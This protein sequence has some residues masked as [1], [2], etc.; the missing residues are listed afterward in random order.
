MK[1]EP[2]ILAI[3]TADKS[4][5]VALLKGRKTL[6]YRK[7]PKEYRR[8][9]KL[10]PSV[11]RVLATAGI[12]K[13]ELDLVAVN[14]GP[15]SH[16]GI[17]VGLAFAKGLALGTGIPIVGFSLFEVLHAAIAE[18]W[19]YVGIAVLVSTTRRTFVTAYF[20]PKH[21]KPIWIKTLT[22][23]ETR[24]EIPSGNVLVGPGVANLEVDTARHQPIPD[25]Y[26]FQTAEVLGR[27]AANAWVAQTIDK[28]RPQPIY[29]SDYWMSDENP[30]EGP[31]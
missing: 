27:L 28:N 21:D 11:E 26:E 5:Q 18:E 4:M 10:L 7:M 22:P 16:T 15:G 13:G 14:N 31:G 1:T 3:D 8:G 19:T 29:L 25:K 12:R 9:E 17:R 2:I 20:P 6:A 30:P 24:T 23:D